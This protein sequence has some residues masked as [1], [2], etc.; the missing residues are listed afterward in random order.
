MKAGE[1]SWGSRLGTSVAQETECSVEEKG[2]SQGTLREPT[3]RAAEGGKQRGGSP[4]CLPGQGPRQP[5][6]GMRSFPQAT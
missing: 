2:G 3:Q 4:S 1:E 6:L 5:A